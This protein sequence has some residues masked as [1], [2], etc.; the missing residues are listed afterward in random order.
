MRWLLVVVLLASSVAF[1]QPDKSKAEAAAREGQQRYQAGEFALAAERFELAFQ[2]DPDP[3]YL[4]NL[5]QSYR[6]GKACAKAAAAYRKLLGLVAQGPN[7]TK[8]QAY[9]EE[10]DACAK[11]QEPVAPPPAGTPPV[12]EAPRLPPPAKKGRSPF[13]YAGIGVTAIGA[14]ELVVGALAM[15]S[16][17]KTQDEREALCS[18][19]CTWSLV[20]A[21]ANSLDSD[22]RRYERRMK[23]GYIAGGITLA[24]GIVMV[25]LTRDPGYEREEMATIVPTDGGA[26]AVGTFHF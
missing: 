16:V 3:A 9:I 4:F 25:L 22:G 8:V 1:A 5:A 13:F 23:I 19:G 15:R 26:M 14:V 18:A 2:L 17:S 12:A 24:A 11:P 7:T 6:L 20:E 10:M 21:R